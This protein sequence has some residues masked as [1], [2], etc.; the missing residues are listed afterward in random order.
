MLRLPAA[1]SQKG[2]LLAMY[3]TTEPF[4][5]GRDSIMSA[6]QSVLIVGV[7]GLWIQLLGFFGRR[8]CRCLAERCAGPCASDV[9]AA[10]GG[11]RW[12][13]C[14]TF[15]RVKSFPFAPLP[16][17]HPSYPNPETGTFQRPIAGTLASLRH[18]MAPA[19]TLLSR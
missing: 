6:Q 5:I 7:G 3:P 15:P 11:C 2:K 19:P 14:S 18:Y 12:S 9:E 1:R 16:S 10:A 4:E 13:L 8:Q 17:D